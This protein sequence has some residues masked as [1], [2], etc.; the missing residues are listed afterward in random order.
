MPTQLRIHVT[1]A[2]LVTIGFALSLAPAQDRR[3]PRGP[4]GEQRQPRLPA[5]T[6]SPQFHV[7][8]GAIGVGRGTETYVLQTPSGQKIELKTRDVLAVKQT[9]PSKQK[10]PAHAVIVL[11]SAV[12]PGR[13]RGAQRVTT[14]SGQELSLPAQDV[15]EV[16]EQ[17]PPTAQAQQPSE[18]QKEA[19]RRDPRFARPARELKQSLRQRPA[20]AI[21]KMPAGVQVEQGGGAKTV[22]LQGAGLERITAAEVVRDGKAVEGASVELSAP[23][24]DGARTVSLMATEDL[25]A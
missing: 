19:A 8:V 22:A 14:V 7:L 2:I 25:P 23:G 16:I 1:C 17:K 3:Q 20:L 15:L 11:A 18:Q 5:A 24:K 13:E 12:Q 9:A 21:A 6:K 4:G 10:Q